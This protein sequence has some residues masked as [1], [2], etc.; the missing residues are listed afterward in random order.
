MPVIV[1]PVRTGRSVPLGSR[2]VPTV[3]PTPVKVMRPRKF[4]A[5]NDTRVEDTASTRVGVPPPVSTLSMK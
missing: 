4:G 1:P 3:S 5:V 2:T